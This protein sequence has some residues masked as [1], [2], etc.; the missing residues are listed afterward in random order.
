M[1]TTKRDKKTQNAIGY[2]ETHLRL[3]IQTLMGNMTIQTAPSSKPN[4]QHGCKRFLVPSL[5]NRG[6]Y[7]SKLNA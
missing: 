3:P 7:L 1:L 2:A 4:H 5:A 6:G